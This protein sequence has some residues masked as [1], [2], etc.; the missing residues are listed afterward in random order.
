MNKYIVL[1][2]QQNKWFR[3]YLIGSIIVGTILQVSVIMIPSLAIIFKVVPLNAIQW[4]IVLALCIMPIIIV[5]LEKFL[6]KK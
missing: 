6:T 4:L 5:E 3:P 1:D 2:T